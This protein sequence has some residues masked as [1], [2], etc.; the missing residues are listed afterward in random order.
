MLVEVTERAMAQCGQTNVLCVGGVGCN[1]RLKKVLSEMAEDH[2][3]R[4][5]CTNER[6]CIDN[7]AMIGWTASLMFHAG[8]KD[9]TVPI[10]EA[11][12]M[13]RY[14]TDD[15]SVIWR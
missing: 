12:C 7:G 11:T 14:R 15:V 10:E 8:G 4:V 13:Q 1:L 3:G 5:F 6:Y 2:D 9:A